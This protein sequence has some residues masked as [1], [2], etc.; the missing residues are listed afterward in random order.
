MKLIVSIMTFSAPRSVSIDCTIS[1]IV[2]FSR[3][4]AMICFGVNLPVIADIKEK[5][6]PLRAA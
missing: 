4:R 2:T 1:Q 3:T 5:L 6:F